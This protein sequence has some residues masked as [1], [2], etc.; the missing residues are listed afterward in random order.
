M[1]KSYNYLNKLELPLKRALR[2][3]YANYKEEYSYE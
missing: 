1:N 2:K 3:L